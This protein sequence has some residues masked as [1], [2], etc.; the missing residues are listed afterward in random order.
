MKKKGFT[1]IE[2]LAVI[3]ILAVIA[4]IATPIVLN[5][6]D[7]ARESARK[8][9]VNGYADA[10]RMA[11]Y[12]YQFANNGSYPTVDKTWA[13]DN[14]KT[15]GDTV[16]CEE[17]Q[18]STTFE[19]VLHKCN[20]GS[21]EKKYC[22]ASGKTYEDC[23]NEEY[24]NIYNSLGNVAVTGKDLVEELKK[25][26]QESNTVGLLKDPDSNSY[27][28]KGTKEEVANNFVWFGGH[29]WRVI[30]INE[31]NSLTMITQ[32]PVTAIHPASS[33]W[34]TEQ[35]YKDSYI[36]T[37][38]NEVFLGSMN[39]ID[40]EKLQ[41]STFNI[42][43]YNNVS[44]ITTTQKVGLLDET[45]YTKTGGA[46]S[47]LDIKDNWW[48]GN[49]YST[50]GVRYV[51]INGD[52]SDNGVADANGV[53]PVIKI[54]N[55]TFS[56]GEGTLSN[57]YREKREAKDITQIKVGEY[58]SIPTSGADC[59]SD[60]KCL[61]RVVSKESNAVK[62]TLNGLLSS[63][64]VFGDT[65]TYVSTR[66]SIASVVT[67]FANTIDNKYRYQGNDTTF[68]IGEYGRGVNYTAAQTP[69]YIGTVGL[70]VVGELFTANDIDLSTSTTKDFV[71]VN[72][73][74]NPIASNWY[75]TMN[76][77]STSDVR[78]VN[79]TGNLNYIGVANA[80]GVRPVLYLNASSSLTFAN[81]EG[82][83]EN[84]FTLE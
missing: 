50:S 32:Q 42:G 11:I 75:W 52:R 62:V 78:S 68:G 48:L 40:K 20:V 41:D 22:H 12:D 35:E 2:L 54:S 66:S 56:E 84:P 51:D 27:Y 9:S 69:T 79:N 4:L 72:T 46:N 25:Q 34:E 63:T 43:I 28:Y 21:N 8:S 76:A 37:W 64:S 55:L 82:T 67:T 80:Y 57:P 45:Q 19:V 31:D 5:V 33:V 1:L 29:L 81:G 3:I 59:G 17:V 83:A 18:F 38:L 10:T 16:N 70:P 65:S 44:E 6:I 53:R 7:N 73:I 49:R 36:N 39:D 23:E 47:F 24:K 74:E 71:N 30:T 60:N 15:K 77:Y 58:I 13:E 61:F 26:Y 14:A